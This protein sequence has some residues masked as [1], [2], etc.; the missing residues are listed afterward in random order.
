MDPDVAKQMAAAWGNAIMRQNDEQTARIGRQS[1]AAAQDMRGLTAGVFR[2][3]AQASDPSTYADLQTSSHVPT[4]QPYVVPN[5]VTPNGT[6]VP[7]AA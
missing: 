5:F 2:L 1:D 4:P 7:K 3:I 6:T